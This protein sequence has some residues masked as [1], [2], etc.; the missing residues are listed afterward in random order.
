MR[1]RV[2][3]L[4]ILACVL[5][6]PFLLCWLVAR[7]VRYAHILALSVS[8]SMVCYACGGEIP[9]TGGPWRCKCDYTYAGHLLK[10]CPVCGRVPRAARCPHCDVTTLLTLDQ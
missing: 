2:T 10:P 7:A 6:L 8:P 9:L 1:E 4:F 5:G 3:P